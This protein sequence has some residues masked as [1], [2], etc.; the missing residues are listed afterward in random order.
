MNNGN[1]FGVEVG[2]IYRD[3]DPRMSD[4]RVKVLAAEG[5][6]ARCVVCNEWGQETGKRTR[7]SLAGLESRF[8]RVSGSTVKADLEAAALEALREWREADR[9][10]IEYRM[11]DSGP[12]SCKRLVELNNAERRKRGALRAATAALPHGEE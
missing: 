3:K 10:L 8:E 1:R 4:R 9:E 7:I 11:P 6:Y 12:D 2:D 5:L